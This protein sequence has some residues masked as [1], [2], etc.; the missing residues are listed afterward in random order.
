MRPIDWNESQVLMS[1]DVMT[2]SM[3][4]FDLEDMYR[5]NCRK[6]L[7]MLMNNR[8]SMERHLGKYSF[9]AI[10]RVV[11]HVKDAQSQLERSVK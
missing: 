4:R 3:A 10:V 6:S 9:K 11:E 5:F 2:S 7:A 8:E 1:I